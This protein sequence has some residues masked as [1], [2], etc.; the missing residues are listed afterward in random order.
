[1]NSLVVVLSLAL[2]APQGA[3]VVTRLPD[4]SM[5]MEPKAWQTIDDEVKRLQAVEQV[6]KAESPPPSSLVPILLGLVLGGAIGF[7][8]TYAVLRPT[9]K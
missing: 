9:E 4:G 7:G 8:V 6:H 1:M 3:P 5:L 2:A